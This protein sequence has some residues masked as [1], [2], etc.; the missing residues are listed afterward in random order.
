M[1]EEIEK[2][3]HDL[4]INLSWDM[5]LIKS[6]MN[7]TLADMTKKI[8][9]RRFKAKNTCL[10]D[11]LEENDHGLMT[12]A[13]YVVDGRSYIIDYKEGKIQESK[14]RHEC[15]EEIDLSEYYDEEEEEDEDE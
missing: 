6:E 2:L 15:K 9:M 14:E 13:V 10:A 5:G 7:N 12:R 1:T 11:V 3:L 8:L 4:Y